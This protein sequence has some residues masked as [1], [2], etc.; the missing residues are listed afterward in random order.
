MMT[1][2]ASELNLAADFSCSGRFSAVGV[3]RDL[4][5]ALSVAIRDLLR[6]REDPELKLVVTHVLATRM[7]GRCGI[8]SAQIQRALVDAMSARLALEWK[9]TIPTIGCVRALFL[10]TRLE[11]TAQPDVFDLGLKL[12][13]TPSFDSAQVPEMEAPSRVR[14]LLRIF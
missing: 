6:Y 9:I 11:K 12:A 8:R 4:S 10:V 1:R 5:L 14:P 2:R 7:S 13:S 3:V